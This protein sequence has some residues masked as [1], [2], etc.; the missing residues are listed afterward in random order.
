MNE[1]TTFG[2][3]GA[4][5][6]I[7]NAVCSR[8]FLNFP[9]QIIEIAGSAAWMIV[10]Y[11]FIIMM[12]FFSIMNKL[13]GKFEGKDIIDISEET[14]GTI[15]RVIVGLLIFLL[16]IAI[17]SIILREYAEN[18]KTIALSDSPLGFVL[19]F[20]LIGMT[21]A[22]FIGLEPIVRF[23]SLVVPLVAITFLFIVF[24]VL[25]Y[26]DPSNFA[27][28]L[29]NGVSKIFG[30]GF[31]SVSLFSPSLY[32]FLIPPFLKTH[33]NLKLSGYISISI[34]AF[35]LGLSAITYTAVYHYPTS[36]ESFLPTFQMARL[37]NYGRFF[38]RIE[39]L[40][41]L[42][43]ASSA[44]MYLSIIMF[45]ASYVFTKTFKLPYYKPLLFLLTVLVFN[46]SLIPP[47][48]ISAIEL[49]IKYYGKFSWMIALLL[50]LLVLLI[51]NVKKKKEVKNSNEKNC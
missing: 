11:I 32:L 40:F 42:A 35:F 19:S 22:C 37:I 38:Q 12:I 8:V 25:P 30:G 27:P 20:F 44:F 49:E 18:M 5:C 45:F 23:H 15:G 48:L 6:L 4:V 31:F 17:G 2:V 50:P 9:R 3:W 33:K 36:L 34:C 28:W 29:G 51:G 41:M 47:N 24:G 7:I 1:K 13:F 14:M 46:L 43:W 16:L 26:Y 10:V 21:V 39:S